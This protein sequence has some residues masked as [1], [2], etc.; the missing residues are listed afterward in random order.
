VRPQSLLRRALRH[1][2]LLHG[3]L[4]LA[5]LFLGA[6][7]YHTGLVAPE[8]TKTVG[9]EFFGNDGPLRDLEVELQAELAKAVE[10]MVHL[11]V[12]DPLRADV[13]VRGRILDYRKRGG[14]RSK[15]NQLLETGVR[16]AVDA[17]LVDPTRRTGDDG[18]PLP[19]R[20]LRSARTSSESGFRLEE[21]DGERA[22]RARVLR[23]LADRL[24]LDLFGAVA[25]EPPADTPQASPGPGPAPKAVPGRSGSPA[26]PIP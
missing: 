20:V 24:A 6:C 16:I 21:P 18:K 14:I 4:L 25:Y 26:G 23:N 17:E 11:R 15:D 12:V 13:V 22:A 7:G 19:P 10:R 8:G 1:W 9:V 5:A 3:P 2:A